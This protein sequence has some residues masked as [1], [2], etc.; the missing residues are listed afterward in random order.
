MYKYPHL[1]TM[2]VSVMEK[3]CLFMA[4][5]ALLQHHR[6]APSPGGLAVSCFAINTKRFKVTSSDRLPPDYSH[7]ITPNRSDRHV[8]PPASIMRLHE[9]FAEK[10]NI[11]R[12]TSS[13][14]GRVMSVRTAKSILVSIPYTAYIP[15]KDIYEDR[16]KIEMAHDE[17]EICNMG[18]LVEIARC[19]NTY[20][21]RKAHD[22]IKVI[23]RAGGGEQIQGEEEE[24]EDEKEDED[25]ASETTIFIKRT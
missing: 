16:S 8:S 14:K 11:Q 24:K 15:Q 7:P 10:L 2:P 20:S 18:D 12:G 19:G 25:E 23:A 5:N 4:R 17:F 3:G 1:L 21:K 13:I 22:L 9:N 6:V